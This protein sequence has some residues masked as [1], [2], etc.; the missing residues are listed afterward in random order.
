MN[1]LHEYK[2][3][4]RAVIISPHFDDAVFSCGGLINQLVKEGPVLIYTIFTDYLSGIK[5]HGVVLS[6]TR[7]QEEIDAA[8]FLGFESRSIGELDAVVR[9]KTYQKL[10]NI[11]RPPIHADTVWLPTLRTKIFKELAQLEFKEL[12]VPLGVGWH[13]DHILTYQLFEP[14]FDHTSIV[15]YEDIFYS[16]IPNSVRYRL[17]EIALYTH[18]V[19]DQSLTKSTMI[20]SWWETSRYYMGTTLMKNLKPWILRVCAVPV[21]SFYF[22]RLISF[23][24]KQSMITSKR[25]FV[26]HHV[27]LSSDTLNRKVD[28]MMLYKSQFKEFFSS[29]EEC[30]RMLTEYAHRIDTTGGA[31]ERYWKITKN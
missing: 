26:P 31:C 2:K 30:V 21:V 1:L 12:Y 16:C 8:H 14:W 13:V 18:D 3:Q 17:H 28:A 6:E 9:R 19:S 27:P 23:H 15:F 5:I 11:F 25:H 7:Q 22:F 29:R 24:R 20:I 10:G 4:Y